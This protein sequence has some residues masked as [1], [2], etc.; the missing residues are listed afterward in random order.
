VLFRSYQAKVGVAYNIN[1]NMSVDVGYKFFGTGDLEYQNMLKVK[2]IYA[3]YIGLSFT[4][5][6]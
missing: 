5:K 3:H 1:D 6:F 2:D 4:W